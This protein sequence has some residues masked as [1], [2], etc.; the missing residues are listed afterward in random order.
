M[1]SSIMIG[2]CHMRLGID[3]I[4]Q[5]VTAKIVYTVSQTNKPPQWIVLDSDGA[6]LRIRY[7]KEKKS[8]LQQ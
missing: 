5:R 8:K 1:V 3:S 6:H 4:T 7:F 2:Q